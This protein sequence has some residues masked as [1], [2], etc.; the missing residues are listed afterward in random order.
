MVTFNS[1][2]RRGVYPRAGLRPDPGAA[3]PPLAVRSGGRKAKVMAERVRSVTLLRISACCDNNRRG[4][5]I[6]CRYPWA[7]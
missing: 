4:C 2:L 5:G 1:P 7:T 3:P 6:I